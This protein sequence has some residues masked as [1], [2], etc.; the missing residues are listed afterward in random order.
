MKIWIAETHFGAVRNC[1]GDFTNYFF[2]DVFFVDGGRGGAK[3]ARC[4][5]T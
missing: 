3:V 1:N 4:P 2:G 5:R